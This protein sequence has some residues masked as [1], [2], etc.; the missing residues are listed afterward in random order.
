MFANMMERAS[1]HRRIC[2]LE[3][4]GWG[5]TPPTRFVG[6]TNRYGAQKQHAERSRGL[7]VLDALASGSAAEIDRRFSNLD[8]SPYEG[9]H[10]VVAD[11]TFAFVLVHDGTRLTRDA[12]KSG[13]PR[14]DGTELRG[15]RSES[16]RPLDARL[17]RRPADLRPRPRSGLH[18]VDA[19]RDPVRHARAPARRANATCRRPTRPNPFRGDPARWHAPRD[20][21]GSEGVRLPFVSQPGI[22]G[23]T[24]PAGAGKTQLGL[25]IAAT[26][27]RQTPTLHLSP[28]IRKAEVEMRLE[29]V[30]GAEDLQLGG[31]RAVLEALSTEEH[32][33]V[34]ID[35]RIN[36]REL[37]AARRAV[38]D[39]DTIVVLIFPA[40]SAEAIRGYVPQQLRIGP[41]SDVAAWLQLDPFITNE[42][43]TL[44]LLMPHRPRT[45]DGWAAVD[46]AVAKNR[47]GV[48]ETRHVRFNGCLFEDEPEDVQLK[49]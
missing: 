35:H 7:L 26:A 11:P 14:G 28:R 5:S 2:W 46:I 31:S 8:V 38:L 47:R 17:I 49:F 43:D 19:L 37:D 10:L 18:P 22:I 12:L 33:F 20:E 4:L 3:E 24:G 39:R 41:P 6:I 34:V 48:S 15:G 1:S 16:E 23:I 32:T 25:Q 9:F 29:E 45:N 44:L 13:R 30:G 27:S 40:N 21:R 36:E 42:L